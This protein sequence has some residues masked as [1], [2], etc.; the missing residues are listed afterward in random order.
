M[1]QI[2]LAKLLKEQSNGSD[3][4]CKGLKIMWAKK[5]KTSKVQGVRLKE[6][7]KRGLN[8]LDKN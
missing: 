4:K 1:Q 6:E 8:T 2:M 7:S 3:K 5:F